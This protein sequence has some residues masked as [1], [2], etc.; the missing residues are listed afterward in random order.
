LFPDAQVWLGPGS[1]VFQSFS[2][3]AAFSTGAS[4]GTKLSTVLTAYL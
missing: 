2:M 3:S 1:N 4:F